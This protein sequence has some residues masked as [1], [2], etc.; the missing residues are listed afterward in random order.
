LLVEQALARLQPGDRVCDV[1]A[2]SGAIAIAVA[3]ERED[4]QVVAVDVSADALA[5]AQRNATDHGCRVGLCRA[6]LLSA[7]CDESFHVIVSNPPYVA[8]TARRTLQRELLHEPAT[9]LFAGA[10]GLDC[11]RRFIPQA[12][13]A[14]KP[15][16]TLLLELGYDSLPGVQ[17]LF[18]AGL[19]SEAKVFED[20][21][22]IPRVLAA[23]RRTS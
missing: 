19:W 10:D 21:A 15:G 1:G 23:Q 12:E 4:V 8:E 3:S 17:A 6:D 5:I 22:G 13:R 18:Q 9:A 16:G 14:L 2:G 11:Y 7:F 20:L